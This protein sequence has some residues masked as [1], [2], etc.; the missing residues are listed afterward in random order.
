M[1]FSSKTRL[2]LARLIPNRPCCV[3]AE[4]DAMM[5][6]EGTTVT[7]ATNDPIEIR[8]GHPALARKVYHLI[9]SI[10]PEATALVHRHGTRRRAYT[11][12][13][14]SGQEAIASAIRDTLADA[15]QRGLPRRRCCRRAFLRGAFLCRG[16][17]SAPSRQY[18]FEIV[19]DDEEFASLLVSCL[20][21]FEQ[22]GR[23]SRRKGAYMVYLKESDGIV[24]ALSLMGA[25]QALLE[26]ENVRIVKG[27]R[28]RANRLVNCETA[29]V[30]KTVNAA[31][32]QMEAIRLID[33][34]HG[35][36]KLPAPLKSLAE[37]RMAHP[38]AS[39][40]ELGEA[41]NPQVSKSSIS[42]RM[43]RL[44]KIADELRQ[45]AAVR[46]TINEGRN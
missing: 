8:L 25:H 43:R 17:L 18:H 30:D 29:N 2:E 14:T 26:L 31:L 28:N 15:D 35:L 33:E 45:N 34:T 5:R 6:A 16:S 24:D 21:S 7:T 41:M 11:V 39:L 20:E 19:V 12:E 42:Y 38:Y 4:L 9:K 37:V 22:S 23:M 1:T 3:A 13:V 36:A 27:I 46:G 32:S 44:M 40:R 10:A